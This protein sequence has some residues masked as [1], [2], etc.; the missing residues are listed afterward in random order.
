MSLAARIT[1]LVSSCGEVARYRSS[2]LVAESDY[3]AK[4]PI[5]D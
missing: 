4:P 1:F 2:I 3:Q 5:N